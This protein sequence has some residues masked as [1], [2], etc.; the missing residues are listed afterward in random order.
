MSIR[1]ERIARLIQREVADILRSEIET[2][3]ASVLTV[4]GARVSPD[5]SVATIYVSF[6]ADAP[7]QRTA[8]LQRI[9]QHLPQIRNVLGNRIRN[10]VRRI[11]EVR[12]R[13][14]DTQQRAN[15]VEELLAR[16]RAE[17]EA[18]LGPGDDDDQR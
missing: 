12:F 14:D 9:R 11:P 8:L 2:A 5:L 1:S 3:D 7:D 4:T 15:R 13:L 17:R 18:R 10:Q 6:L 16:A